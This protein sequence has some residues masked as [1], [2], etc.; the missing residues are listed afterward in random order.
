MSDEQDRKEVFAWF[1]GAS[2]YAQCVEVELWIARLFLLRE[3]GPRPRDDEWQR[4]ETEPLT[5][6]RLLGL[7]QT[8]IGLE[9]AEM[10]VLET[11]LKK[12]NWLSHKYWE[13]RS[14]LLASSAGCDQAVAE[15]ADLC[16]VFKRGD[17]VARGLSARIRAQIGVSEQWVKELQDEYVERLRGGESHETILQ[18]QE[19]RL[20]RL[21]PGA[22]EGGT[23][24]L[25]SR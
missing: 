16:E 10:E 17:E 20:K 2:Y 21:Q 18:D 14:H 19:E 6:G 7:V 25:S 9:S 4:F 1:G 3:N 5:M 15:L 22:G 12:R 24:G 13:E 11:C 23:A 8:G